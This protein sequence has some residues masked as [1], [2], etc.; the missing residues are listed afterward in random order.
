M[1]LLKSFLKNNNRFTNKKFFKFQKATSQ[2]CDEEIKEEELKKSKHQ[3]KT[4]LAEINE[5]LK[6]RNKID[7]EK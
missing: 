1:E 3:Q 7:L 5:N 6:I 2:F 4:T